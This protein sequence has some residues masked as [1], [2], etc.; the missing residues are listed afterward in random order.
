[1]K[2]LK[3][4]TPF[5]TRYLK[6]SDKNKPI[7]WFLSYP[8]APNYGEVYL[9][10]VIKKMKTLPV[11]FLDLGDKKE[12]FLPSKEKIQEGQKVYIKIEKEARFHK[13]AT[14]SLLSKEEVLKIEE[15]GFKQPSLENFFKAEGFL[16]EDVDEENRDLFEEAF[17]KL[18]DLKIPLLTGAAKGAEIFWQQTEA[19][20]SFD[21]DS[22]QSSASFSKINEAAIEKIADEIV[23]RHLS[24]NLVIDTIGSKRVSFQKPVYK[25]LIKCLQEKEVDVKAS[26]ISPLGFL[27]VQIKRTYSNFYERFN[28]E[29]KQALYLLRKIYQDKRQFIT[30]I[31]LPLEIEGIL[32][33]VLR[34]YYEK[35]RD[36]RRIK[37]T[38]QRADKIKIKERKND[39]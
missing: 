33:G 12:A 36:K 17:E 38:L 19:L 27:E 11:Y 15:E 23:L 37:I 7:E 30:E 2:I 31:E 9:A 5:E 21:I 3:D 28:I 34:P 35:I 24:G 39:G 8:F 22:A 25:K 18:V 14:A 6:V 32:K 1:M 10:T 20:H 4:E 29:M 13:F 16:I 26:G